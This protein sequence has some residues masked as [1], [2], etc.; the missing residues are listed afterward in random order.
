M[1]NYSEILVGG[2]GKEYVFPMLCE[3]NRIARNGWDWR[4]NAP[5][6]ETYL[7]ASQIN[8]YIGEDDV[9]EGDP[10]TWVFCAECYGHYKRLRV[11]ADRGAYA[12]FTGG[13]MPLPLLAAQR[14]HVGRELGLGAIIR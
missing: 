3:T 1:G 4:C 13:D 8:Q 6:G 9:P 2:K 11:V 5:G 12:R 10:H 14:A 7:T